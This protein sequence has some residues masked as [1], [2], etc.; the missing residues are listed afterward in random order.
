MR[1]TRGR[2]HRT[3]GGLDGLAL[4]PSTYTA[5]PHSRT[6]ILAAHRDTAISE[7]IASGRTEGVVRLAG[8]ITSMQRKMTKQGNPWAIVNLV[9]RD[10]QLE[11]LF[12]PA[13]YTLVMGALVEDRGW[14]NSEA[15]WPRGS[16]QYNTTPPS[17]CGSSTTSA[18]ATAT[19]EPQAAR[20]DLRRHRAADTASGESITGR[21]CE[22]HAVPALGTSPRG[23]L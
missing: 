18:C 5:P 22:P 19:C 16:S 9:D 1:D 15:S 21:T 3:V 12:F 7:L 8:L 14:S 23:R 11:T 13:T 2:V 6:P 10:G 20:T 4:L 17:A